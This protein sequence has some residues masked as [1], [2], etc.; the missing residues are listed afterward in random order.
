MIHS[1]IIFILD[2]REFSYWILQKCCPI[3][4]FMLTSSVPEPLV[5]KAVFSSFNCLEIFVE[6]QLLI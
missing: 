6:H 5:K 3:F 1:D 4:F 2:T